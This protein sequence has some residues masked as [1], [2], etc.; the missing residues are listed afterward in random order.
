MSRYK[1]GLE[2]YLRV[3]KLHREAEIEIATLKYDAKQT[4]MIVENLV[5]EI[6]N[7]ISK[8]DEDWMRG[9]LVDL[10]KAVKSNMQVQI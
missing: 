4:R 6:E 7:N 10:L 2:K 5:E 9:V 8:S 1:V 3:E